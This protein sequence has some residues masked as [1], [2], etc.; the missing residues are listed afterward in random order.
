MKKDREQKILSYLAQN[1]FLSTADAV[2]LFNASEATVRRLFNI[3]A[4]HNTVRRVRG[5]VK[6]LSGGHGQEVPVSLRGQW[7]SAE[8]RKIAEKAVGFIPSSGTS[9][10]VHGGS[11]TCFL[12]MYLN[13]G[14]A[15]VDSLTICRILADRFQT[16]G[17]PEV[18]LIGG[19]LHLTTDVV[20][21]CCALENIAR[22]HTDILFLSSSGMDE[23]GLLDANDDSVAIQRAMV[24]H[25]D[26]VILLADHSKFGNLAMSRGVPWENIHTLITDFWPDN[27][28]F[29][30]GVRAKGVQV[31]LV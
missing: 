10:F 12:G 4:E 18:L 14:T 19:K 28:E 25:T 24:A 15:I 11:T 17:G 6:N 29:L 26:R 5:G 16:G 30:K 1:D 21:G 8:K 20:L 22:Y 23:H 3:L 31:V 27:H 9:F 7:F 2:R 13:H